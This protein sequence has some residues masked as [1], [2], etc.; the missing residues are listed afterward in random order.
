MDTTGNSLSRASYTLRQLL[1]LS[2]YSNL[3]RIVSHCIFIHGT[4]LAHE[5][6]RQNDWERS[7]THSLLSY[8]ISLM[9]Q[10]SRRSD[11]L[12]RSVHC[13]LIRY[14]RTMVLSIYLTMI[15]TIRRPMSRRYSMSCS[16]LGRPKKVLQKIIPL[17]LP[18]L[19][20]ADPFTR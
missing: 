15:R 18:H 17:Q 19:P 8:L 6:P 13:S 2:S 4:S 16:K 14:S 7:K 11:C 20:P 3:Y 12:A 9:F 1:R 10:L 5:P